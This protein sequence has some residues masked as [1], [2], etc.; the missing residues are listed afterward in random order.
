MRLNAVIARS[1]P[2]LLGYRFIVLAR[3]KGGALG[4]GNA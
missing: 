4:A 2:R 3:P 1:V